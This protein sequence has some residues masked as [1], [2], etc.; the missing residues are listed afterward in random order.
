MT[1]VSG[2]VVMSGPG[3]SALATSAD[4]A[5]PKPAVVRNSV[6]Y[7]RD[8]ATSGTADHVLVY[9]NPGD[10]PLFSDWDGNGTRTPG[11][12][13]NGVWY[14]RNSQTT[15]VADVAFRYGDNADTPVV[16]DWNADGI[17]SPGVA[18]AGDDGQPNGG[19]TNCSDCP[20]RWL[21]RNENSSGVADTEYVCGYERPVPADWTGSGRT[22]CGYVLNGSWVVTTATSPFQRTFT[23]GNPGDAAFAWS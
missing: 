11:V 16:G 4:A 23:Y 9:G 17:D 19:D 6:W 15:G 1:I 12:V 3:G 20:F 14:L 7:L 22:T 13:R 8:T 18:R 2:L 5:A 10:V 21:L